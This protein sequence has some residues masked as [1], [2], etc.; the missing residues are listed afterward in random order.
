MWGFVC[1]YFKHLSSRINHKNQLSYGSV[2]LINLNWK[3]FSISLYSGI[4]VQI[5]SNP[6]I[7]LFEQHC[8]SILQGPFC[9]AESVLAPEQHWF[10][11]VWLKPAWQSVLPQ[12]P[13][14]RGK[15]AGTS[16]WAASGCNAR[17][18]A[19]DQHGR[20]GWALHLTCVQISYTTLAVNGTENTSYVSQ[21]KEQVFVAMTKRF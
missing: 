7:L 1:L 5:P 17:C 2:S 3:C 6:V 8:L 11:S 18:T 15:I 20:V 13:V 21:V 10:Q 12:R 4:S 19:S 14:R 16:G 9:A